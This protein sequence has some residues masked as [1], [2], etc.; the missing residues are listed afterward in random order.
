MYA[1]HD[2]AIAATELRNTIHDAASGDPSRQAAAG[3]A[4]DQMWRADAERQ[5]AEGPGEPSREVVH[6]FARLTPDS[7]LGAEPQPWSFIGE[8]TKA[9]EASTRDLYHKADTENNRGEGYVRSWDEIR[10]GFK[11]AGHQVDEQVTQAR[12]DLGLPTEFAASPSK[13]KHRKQYV[14][15]HASTKEIEAQ[16]INKDK[17]GGAQV[18]PDVDPAVPDPDATVIAHEEYGPAPVALRR[19]G[20][21]PA[22]AE[23]TSLPHDG[24]VIW[25]NHSYPNAGSA[26][27][28][29]APAPRPQEGRTFRWNQL[30]EDGS[31]GRPDIGGIP[32][33]PAAPIPHPAGESWDDGVFQRAHTEQGRRDRVRRAQLVLA[34]GTTAAVAGIALVDGAL[35]ARGIH[36][37]TAPGAGR[38]VAEGVRHVMNSDT[39]RQFGGQWRSAAKS[40]DIVSRGIAHAGEHGGQVQMHSGDTPWGIAEQA[41]EKRGNLHPSNADIQIE[42]A[43]IMRHLM[44]VR[45][46]GRFTWEAATRVA[47]TL[48]P[49]TELQT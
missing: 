26:D 21:R 47:R 46:L 25:A 35:I 48:R 36:L 7:Q 27:R 22:S 30:P 44:Q 31:L 37:R 2:P 24:R 32:L 12:A 38:A 23:P 4:L 14:G 19:P 3:V 49:G 11:E 43:R 17:D 10:A 1:S 39:L 15:K 8:Q 42:D 9:A 34:L 29:G 41:L 18:R 6:D 13:G 28:T 5:H 16:K 33:V 20:V 40:G 45:H